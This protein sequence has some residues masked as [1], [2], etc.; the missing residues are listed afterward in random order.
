MLN[1]IIKIDNSNGL[2][3]SR[4]KGKGKS[5]LRIQTDLILE[6][7]KWFGDMG[8]SE[9]LLT[10]WIDELIVDKRRTEALLNDLLLCLLIYKGLTKKHLNHFCRFL[11]IRFR[12]K[13]LLVKIDYLQ[14]MVNESISELYKENKNS[15]NKKRN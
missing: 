15:I 7:Y 6:I 3:H 13:R 11:F 2:F 14:T 5:V 4:G 9:K 8:V 1:D 10:K 12:P